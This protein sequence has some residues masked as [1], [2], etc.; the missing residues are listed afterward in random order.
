MSDDLKKYAEENKIVEMRTGSHL[1]GTNTEDSDEDFVGI[2]M[3]PEE[4]VLGLKTVKE[5]DF[6]IKDKDSLGKNTKEAVDRKLYEFRKFIQ[7]AMDNNPNIIEMLFVN[8]EN[9]INI[10]II[11]E[12]LLAMNHLFPSKVAA[13]RFCAYARSQKHKMIIKR[14]HFNELTMAKDLLAQMDPKLT[15][16]EVY[17]NCEVKYKSIDAYKPLFWKKD[18]SFHVR[19][20]DLCFEPGIYAKKAL[21]QVKERLEKATNRTELITKYGFDAKFGSHS[22]RLLSEGLFLLDN[23]YLAFPL[24]NREEILDIKQGKWK[25]E[26]VLERCEDLEKQIDFSLSSSPL[27][28]TAYYKEIEIFT[29]EQ[30]REYLFGRS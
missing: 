23:G 24:P 28:K 22:I 19:V 1:Y 10:N 13:D 8:K 27:P 6:S 9:I 15:M 12:R 3:P 16:A 11:G 30:M 29:I 7:L 21:K 25:L 14:D 20:G 5:V 4:Y 17:L 26:E 18:N 2:F